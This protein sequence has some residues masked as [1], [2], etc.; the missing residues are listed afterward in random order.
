MGSAI[1]LSPPCRMMSVVE[2]IEET[3]STHVIIIDSGDR[4]FLR[5]SCITRVVDLGYNGTMLF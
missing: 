3:Y 2:H 1:M 5:L 4:T